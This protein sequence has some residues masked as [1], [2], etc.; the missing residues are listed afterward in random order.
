MLNVGLRGLVNSLWANRLDKTVG[1]HGWN[2]L[3]TRLAWCHPV[4]VRQ[5]NGHASG[6]WRKQVALI[7]VGLHPVQY[8]ISSNVHC[9]RKR[10]TKS[11]RTVILWCSSYCST[12]IEQQQ[13]ARL[14][15]T[16]GR[17]KTQHFLYSR[18]QAVQAH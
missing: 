8:A 17:R 2:A 16:L 18:M 15:F 14:C 11:E 10:I 3:G 4:L 13:R 12:L 9:L 5:L 1:T 6:W 7:L